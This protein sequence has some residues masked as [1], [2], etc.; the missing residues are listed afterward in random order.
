MQRMFLGKVNE[1]YLGLPEI[2][3]RE[4]FTLAPLAVIVVVLGVYPSA[5]LDLTSASLNSLNQFVLSNL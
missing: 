3:G 1:K 5:L 4:L 2:N